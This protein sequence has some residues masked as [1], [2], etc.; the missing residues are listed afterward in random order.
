MS[1]AGFYIGIARARLV[2][3]QE[4]LAMTDQLKLSNPALEEQRQANLAAFKANADAL[5]W[6]IARLTAKV[7]RSIGVLPSALTASFLGAS[8]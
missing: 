4:E 6:D 2:L 7:A 1:E 3:Q 8:A 5:G